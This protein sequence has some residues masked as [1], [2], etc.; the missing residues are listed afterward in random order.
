MADNVETLILELLGWVEHRERTYEETMNAWRTS[1]PRLPV[2]EDANDRG[3]V[4]T[5]SESGHLIVR[6]TPRGRAFLTEHRSQT[7][8]RRVSTSG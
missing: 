5:I 4:E 2:W 6:V 3:L 8:A 1:C 7:C